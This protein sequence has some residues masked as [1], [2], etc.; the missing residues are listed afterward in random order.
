MS[1][2]SSQSWRGRAA[3]PGPATQRGRAGGTTPGVRDPYYARPSLEPAGGSPLG[4]CGEWGTACGPQ[5]GL[6]GGAALPGAWGWGGGGWG[7][8]VVMGTRR[9][10]A[11]WEGSWQP[12][13]AALPPPL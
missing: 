10:L 6:A 5:R 11:G 9:P 4:H 8:R 13:L 7:V 3:R 12:R 1:R 2:G